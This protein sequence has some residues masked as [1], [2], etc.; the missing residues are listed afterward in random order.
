MSV[1]TH[2]RRSKLL[3]LAAEIVRDARM[4]RAAL[5]AELNF[6]RHRASAEHGGRFARAAQDRRPGAVET[7]RT[8]PCAHIPPV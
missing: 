8:S 7:I 1:S 3:V 2:H 5:E 6:N 4:Q